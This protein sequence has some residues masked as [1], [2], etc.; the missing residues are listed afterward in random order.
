MTDA[1]SPRFTFDVGVDLPSDR[2]RVHSFPPDQ[3][4]GETFL[5]RFE[6]GEDFWIGEFWAPSLRGGL[7]EVHRW[8]GESHAAVFVHG[9]DYLVDVRRPD[10]WRILERPTPMRQFLLLPAHRLVLLAGG[11]DMA[12]YGEAGLL[13][14]S[15][16][17]VIDDLKIRDVLD[18]RIRCTGYVPWS[19]EEEI[20]VDLDTGEPLDERVK[21]FAMR[22]S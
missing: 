10:Q 6:T 16:R 20:E 2:Q 12:C 4:R 11:C 19:D 21:E 14:S 5:V 15:R 7:S 8:L 17:L 9:R 13:W 22:A 18:R 3:T 1:P